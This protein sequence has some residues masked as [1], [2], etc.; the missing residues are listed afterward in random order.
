MN[1]N[2]NYSLPLFFLVC[3]TGLPLFGMNPTK[4]RTHTGQ[5]PQTAFMSSFMIKP[6]KPRKKSKESAATQEQALASSAHGVFGS[7]KATSQQEL[8]VAHSQTASQTTLMAGAAG[9]ATAVGTSLPS[10]TPLLVHFSPDQAV[11]PIE[12]GE[13]AQQFGLQLVHH[14]QHI[15]YVIF[16]LFPENEDYS[17]DEDADDTDCSSA[18]RHGA[19]TF[20]F[21]EEAFRG[22]Q[23]GKYLLDAACNTLQD[24]SCQKIELD[25]A[26]TDAGSLEKL[27]RFYKR[28]GFQEEEGCGLATIDPQDPNPTV[29]MYKLLGAG[30]R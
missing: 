17:S 2:Y 21:V 29:P 5:P 30:S 18:P 19:I 26:P 15:G 28:A 7:F 20:M 23:H 13:H 9:P 24:L 11:N 4:K 6:S 1:K 10:E 22:K 25:A 8:P 27:V 16:E 3:V 12:H 14:D